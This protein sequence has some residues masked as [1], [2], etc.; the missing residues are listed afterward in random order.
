[1]KNLSQEEWKTLASSS[2]NSII[3]DVRTPQEWA[4]GIIPGAI[5]LDI[6]NTDHFIDEIKKLDR[7]KEYF[8]Y[9]R[10]GARSGQACQM[11]D[12]LGFESASNLVGGI[13]EWN[14]D[15]E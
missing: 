13:L 10:S 3:I 4:E 5:Q 2:E 15:L 8:V 14:G 6:R 12:Q 9:C 7:Q 1:M 11:M